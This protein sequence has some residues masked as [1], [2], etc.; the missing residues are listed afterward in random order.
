[1][2]IITRKDYMAGKAT[3]RQYYGQFVN[4]AVTSWV[5]RKIGIDRLLKST[6]QHLNDIPLSLWDSYYGAMLLDGTARKVAAANGG[7]VSLSDAVCVAK[8]AAHQL[9]E[10]S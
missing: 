6:D 1:M 10:A 9:I 4:P 8:E 2:T 5:R 7:G 3:H